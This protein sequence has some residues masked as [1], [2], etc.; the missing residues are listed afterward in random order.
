MKDALDNEIQ[1]GKIYGYSQRRDGFV[2]VVVGR[3]IKKKEDVYNKNVT[4]EILS[5]KYALGDRELGKDDKNRRLFDRRPAQK[6]TVIPNSLF[7]VYE[8]DLWNVFINK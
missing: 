5:R 8:T 3:A 7:P 4:L 2:Y 6:I 1:I